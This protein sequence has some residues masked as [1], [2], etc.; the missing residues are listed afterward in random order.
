MCDI[1]A[2]LP[3]IR[4]K[5]RPCHFCGEHTGYFILLPKVGPLRSPNDHRGMH[6]IKITHINCIDDWEVQLELAKQEVTSVELE[7]FTDHWGEEFALCQASDFEFGIL[8]TNQLQRSRV[9]F[10]ELSRRMG[11]LD[12]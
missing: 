8:D 4:I 3:F 12:L 10:Q 6:I 5:Y 7:E 11:A 1:S 9:L 2:P